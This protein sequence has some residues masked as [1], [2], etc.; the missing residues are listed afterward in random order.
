MVEISVEDQGIG[1]DE[2]HLHR[3]F[4]P[5]FTTKKRGSGLGLTTCYS[6]VRNHQ[7]R[8]TAES[9]RGHGATFRVYLPAS[10][11]QPAP[12]AAEDAAVPGRGRILV[13]DDEELVRSVSS[14]MLAYLGYEVETAA[15][16]EEAIEKYAAA[17]AAK[18]PFDA[19]ILDITVPGGMG[20]G[21]AIERL[22][23][24]DPD[25]RA[26]AS[27]GYSNDPI[28]ADFRGRGF[29]GIAAKPYDLRGLSRALRD[30]LSEPP[31]P[32]AGT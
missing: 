13:M 28:M 8:I 17:R 12:R 23:A 24:I 20:G 25:V 1:I 9:R 19:V 31:Q 4:D 6:I 30:V 15:D 22:R 27:S 10:A 18:Q 26:V 11:A 5:F 3:V 2:E 7:G 14:Q 16:G 21:Q 32:S 29:R